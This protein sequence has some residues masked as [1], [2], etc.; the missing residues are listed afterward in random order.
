MK[1]QEEER[2]QESE[3]ALTESK[4]QARQQ[5]AETRKEFEQRIAELE[6]AQ[7]ASADSLSSALATAQNKCSSLG[8]EVEALQTKLEEMEKARH[9]N[10]V[11]HSFI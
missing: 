2:I 4:N 6:T 8:E 7:G 9:C 11:I 5:L 1:Q 3:N 10:L